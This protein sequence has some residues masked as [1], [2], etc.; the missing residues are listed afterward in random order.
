MINGD[1]YFSKYKDSTLAFWIVAHIHQLDTH[2]KWSAEIFSK[3]DNESITHSRWFFN[4]YFCDTVV[5]HEFIKRGIIADVKLDKNKEIVKLYRDDLL[6]TIAASKPFL[7][8]PVSEE[9]QSFYAERRTPNKSIWFEIVVNAFNEETVQFSLSLWAYKYLLT[10]LKLTKQE[11]YIFSDRLDAKIRFEQEW[12]PI[13]GVISQ[14]EYISKKS[15]ILSCI[16][17][18]LLHE[19][20]H[21]RNLSDQQAKSSC[22]SLFPLIERVLRSHSTSM[23]WKGKTN[24]FD[25]LITQYDLNSNLSKELISLLRFIVKP[26]RDMIEHGIDLSMTVSKVILTTMLD[27]L[28]KFVG[29][30]EV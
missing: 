21:L 17:K 6:K 4:N 28:V 2:V 5:L 15:M 13:N 20:S 23:A 11:Y 9:A 16:E 8:I 24:N 26:M 22:R 12:F 7:I 10:D 27:I 25:N 1:S 30:I 14:L 3:N 29:E 18:D 19:L